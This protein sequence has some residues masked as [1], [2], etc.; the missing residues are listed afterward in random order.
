MKIV[1]I[2]ADD[3]YKITEGKVYKCLNS[4]GEY[5]EFPEYYLIIN[6]VKQKYLVLRDRFITLAEY[7]DKR[8]DEILD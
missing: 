3:C 1:C 4:K 8:L 2:K 5:G 6:D 7:R